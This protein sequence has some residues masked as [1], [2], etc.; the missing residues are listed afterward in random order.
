[1]AD[2]VVLLILDGFGISSE[3][4]GNAVIAA[5]TPNLEK[6]SRE[7]PGTTLRAS[8]VEVGLAWGEMGSSEVGHTNLGAGL[9]IYQNLPRI[10]LAIEDGSFFSLPSWEKAAAHAAENKSDL[11]LIGLVSNG[12]V[13]SHIDHLF[14]LL[15]VFKKLRFRRNI[16]L[17]IF[18]D[19]QDTAPQ[20][21]VK[22]LEM[23]EEKISG[24]DNV[25]I[26]TVIGR[27]Y[28]MDKNENWN[29][30]RLAYDCLTLGK[31]IGVASAEAAFKTAY[32]NGL[33]DENLEPTVIIGEDGSPVGLI[34][35]NDSV[36]FTNFRA[37][38]ARQLTQAFVFPEFR[39]FPRERIPGL[40]FISMVSYGVGYPI[41]SAFS[42]QFITMPLAK[43]ISDAGKKQFHIAETEK[44]AHVTY[45]FNGG[46]EKE[47][48]G[49]DREIISSKQV[50][51]YDLKPE[52]SAYE[53]T[54]RVVDEIKKAKYDFLAVNLAN[55]DL[56]G[57]T[58][59]FKAGVKAVEVLDE[60]VGD[61]SKAVLESGG[62]LIITGDHG[63]VE[64]MINIET[65]EVDKEHSIN[66]VPLWIV[67]NRYKKEIPAPVEGFAV[68]PGGI[69]ADVAP[70]VLDIMGIK[71]PAEMTGA[72]LLGVI[73]DCPLPK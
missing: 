53:I 55:G 9:V 18:T 68:E 41:E 37:D 67:G 6:I 39:N 21:G 59:I 72:G 11:H 34:K 65:G 69:L 50:K 10:N 30:T 49:E 7:Y 64:E 20:S 23:L 17:H 12:G 52:M 46:T 60:C 4:N 61:I 45:F 31:G 38:R 16:F 54:G 63:N 27:Y 5:K 43:A 3:K 42:A 35:E 57:H 36:I 73:S 51:S 25:R 22:F 19:G 47:F 62:T 13:H 48:P 15:D 58:G 33:I 32:D 14:A 1:M 29:R 2:P 66:P 8:G 40:E 56:V 26:A 28:S 71:K 44:Y 70:T 24:F